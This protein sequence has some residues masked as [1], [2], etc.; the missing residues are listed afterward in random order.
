MTGSEYC[1]EW[2]GIVEF[3]DE[4]GEPITLDTAEEEDNQKSNMLVTCNILV[5]DAAYLKGKTV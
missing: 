4:D 5:E 2:R 1:R 3:D